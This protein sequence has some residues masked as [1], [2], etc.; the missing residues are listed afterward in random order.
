MAARCVL[1]PQ[2][3]E[4]MQP[5][6]NCLHFIH[7]HRE[8]VCD[9]IDICRELKY[10]IDHS[11][12]CDSTT[13]M[14]WACDDHEMYLCDGHVKR[15]QFLCPYHKAQTATSPMSTQLSCAQC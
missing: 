13:V 15:F 1:P 2:K 10:Q 6:T 4:N 14:I 3:Q 11:I 12:Q 8:I 5:E 9:Y 7:S